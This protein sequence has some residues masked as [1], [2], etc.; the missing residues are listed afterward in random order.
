MNRKT[1]LRR[2]EA[3]RDRLR[4]ARDAVERDKLGGETEYETFGLLSPIDQHQ[5]E[6]GSEM[7][8]REK[9]FAIRDRIDTDLRDLDDALRR[10]ERGTYGLCETCGQAIPDARLM[11]VPATRFC[12]AHEVQ[13]ELH[14]RSGSFPVDEH[15]EGAESA[16]QAAER[17]ALE[18]LDFLRDEDG[19]DQQYVVAAEDMALH[20]TTTGRTPKLDAGR[21]EVAELAE[22]AEP[23]ESAQSRRQRAKRAARKTGD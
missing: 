13:W 20:Q 19:F 8:E 5:A 15:A 2:L 17:E 9:E 1:A 11:A 10:L 18:H 12:V 21:L 7:F 16:E 22:L 3:D 14:S 6:N 23:A 4:Q